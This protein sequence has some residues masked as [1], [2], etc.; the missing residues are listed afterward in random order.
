[1]GSIRGDTAMN[2]E[3]VE[4]FRTSLMTQKQ[5]LLKQTQLQNTLDKAKMDPDLKKKE[6][7]QKSTKAIILGAL[8]KISGGSRKNSKEQKLDSSPAEPSEP[9]PAS[10][11]KA[12]C[13]IVCAPPPVLPSPRQ[14]KKK[15]PVPSD[16][17]LLTKVRPDPI[18][19]RIRSFNKSLKKASS[20]RAARERTADL[21]KEKIETPVMVLNNEISFKVKKS[22][23]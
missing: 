19:K 13:P 20:F 4:S 14:E 2:V 21:V 9:S 7:E 23:L 8:R 1:M 11:L 12:E 15:T 10:F 3:R 18:L 6:E 16:S 22:K 17:P 5:R